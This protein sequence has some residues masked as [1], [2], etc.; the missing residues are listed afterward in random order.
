MR[1]AQLS[2]SAGCHRVG[3]IRPHDSVMLQVGQRWR[4]Y[5]I[6]RRDHAGAQPD[7]AAR[8]LARRGQRLIEIESAEPATT[9]PIGRV[10]S[11]T[12]ASP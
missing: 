7:V 12:D 4:R 6:K 8:V 5:I 10:P 3:E 1:R 11:P 2:D 9:W